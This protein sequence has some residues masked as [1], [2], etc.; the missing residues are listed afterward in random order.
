MQSLTIRQA[1]I[2]DCPGIH[3][4]HAGTEGPWANMDECAPWIEKRL[5][6]GFYVQ[7]AEQNN[8]IVGHA[9][10][11]ETPSPDGKYL[12]LC[13][14]QI[15]A[16]HQGRGI[17]RAMV[18]DGI[19]MAKNLGCTK[20]VC[21]PDEETGSEK[22]YAKCGFVTG[23]QISSISLPTADYGYSQSYTEADNLSYELVR[24]RHFLFG[25]S[26]VSPRHMWEVN[27][28]KPA[29][30]NRITTTLISNDGDYIQLCALYNNP[31]KAWA[32]C[33]SDAPEAV[34]VKDVLSL[35]K[36]KGFDE[37]SFDFF[38]E[39][40]NYFCEF[41]VKPEPYSVEIY[42]KVTI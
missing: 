1:T 39:N 20:V 23:R 35:G 28:E 2:N 33:W 19:R 25:L 10:W 4:V 29:G 22:F 16:Q 8:Q 32:L 3:G 12:Y 42:R 14:M 38:A 5:Q 41:D 15:H 40:V 6:R 7:V 30:D 31:R 21:I 11:L 34:L 9:E 17:G 36:A 27:N 18:N 37:V 26:Q 24:D 13:V